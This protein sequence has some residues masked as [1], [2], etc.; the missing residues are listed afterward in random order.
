MMVKFEVDSVLEKIIYGKEELATSPFEYSDRDHKKARNLVVE[1]LRTQQEYYG[2]LDRLIRWKNAPIPMSKDYGPLAQRWV[3]NEKKSTKSFLGVTFPLLFGMNYTIDLESSLP[4]IVFS[5]AAIGGLFY[6]EFLKRQNRAFERSP[7]VQ[8]F[9]CDLS[10]MYAY[11][12]HFK[13]GNCAILHGRIIDYSQSIKS[14]R[15]YFKSEGISEKE[16]F[17]F[18]KELDRLNYAYRVLPKVVGDIAKEK[19]GELGP[20]IPGVYYHVRVSQDEIF[21]EDNHQTVRIL[22]GIPDSLKKYMGI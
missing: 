15:S 1:M 4:F 2:E 6:S 21:I 16:L 11:K 7:D 3:E 5:S 17:P 19:K 18:K 12:K 8:N 22:N 9:I 13:E 14:T 20:F 10:K